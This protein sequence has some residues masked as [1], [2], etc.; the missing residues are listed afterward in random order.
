MTTNTVRKQI[1]FNYI[2]YTLYQLLTLITPLITTPYV[3]RVL[4]A[5]G[6]GKISYTHAIV[7][8]V[9][10][11]FTF[12]TNIYA[13]RKMAFLQGNKKEQSKLFGEILSIRAIMLLIG[14]CVYTLIIA[15]EKTNYVMM[16][17]QGTYLL[18][19]FINIDWL[20]SGNEDFK[21]TITRNFAIKILG[22]LAV[23]LFVRDKQDVNLYAGIL[24]LSIFL[25]NLSLWW[26]LPKYIEK[27][28]LDLSYAKNHIIGSMKLFMPQLA[29]TIY[30]YFDKIM[31][32]LMTA[33][34]TENGYYEQTQK[35]IRLSLTVIT[36]LP[37][38][39]LPRM[40]NI[41]AK[42]EEEKLKDYLNMSLQFVFVLGIPIMCG[43]I[44]ISDGIVGWFFGAGY[45]VVE[46]LLKV[47]APVV[48]FNSIYNVIGYQ[49]FLA[50]KKETKYTYIILVGSVTN[51]ILNFVLI[52]DFASLGAIIG[53]VLA[54]AVVSM[55]MLFYIRK[56]LNKKFLCITILK[57]VIGGIIMGIVVWILNRIMGYG[58]V[59]T[60]TVIL[61]GAVVYIIT[62]IIAKETLIVKVFNSLRRK[63]R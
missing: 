58:I 45:E 26:Y 40:A 6:I 56:L 59:Q 62:E 30:A 22:I 19:E 41:F 3:S 48:I 25:G 11:L 37:T 28:N 1:G 13:N 4:T 39:M 14:V 44:A 51:V 54:E 7:Q 46:L 16:L 21:L 18:A 63:Q 55:I 15:I 31:L 52:P 27:I 29:G 35:I 42:N 57:T 17:V 23:F 49:Y 34:D 38:V 33:A 53:S 50:T 43:I 20:F 60:F 24:G 61:V 8:Y 47:L 32:G 10:V 12:G 2:F 9:I 36:A 5:D